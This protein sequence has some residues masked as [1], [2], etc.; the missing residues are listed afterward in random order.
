M[1]NGVVIKSTGSWFWVR[2]GETVWRCKIRGKFRTQ[3]LRTTNPLAVGDVVD[4][5]AVDGRD[6]I[7]TGIS[8]RRNYII[9]RSTNLSKEAHIL[10][11]NVDQALLV[12][13]IVFPETTTTFIDRFL[14]SAEAYRIPARLVF[15]K[16]DL[17]SAEINVYLSELM[18]MYRKIG[19]DCFTVSALRGTNLEQIR[20]LLAD[21][22]SVISGH[23]GS[24]KSTLINALDPAL[25]LRTGE[26]SDYHYKGKHTTTF[27]EMFYL[28]SGGAIIDT[29]G[30]KAMGMVDMS[31]DPVSHYFVEMFALQADCQYNNCTHTHEPGCAVKQ[32]L[33]LGKV[34]PSRYASYLS[35]LEEDT[36]KYRRNRY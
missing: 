31:E 12:V 30:I 19:Y 22:V 16:T 4:F 6:G 36:G 15:N 35:I 32:A 8:P 29:P 5:E 33:D 20:A 14:A 27:A 10:A 2:H 23:S 24:G 13:T 3:D 25:A 18:E 21:R 28:S 9:R 11:A 26:I 17:Y 7:I 34:S 1:E